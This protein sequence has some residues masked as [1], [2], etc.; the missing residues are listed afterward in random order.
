M[1]EAWFGRLFTV[2]A[3]QGRGAADRRQQKRATRCSDL[4][5]ELTVV[6]TIGPRQALGQI[7]SQFAVCL[8]AKISGDV[9]CLSGQ[10]AVLQCTHKERDFEVDDTK[11]Q[12]DSGD[13][14]ERQ[15]QDQF[16]E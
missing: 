10:A 15:A 1:K 14:R 6:G 8:Y 5:H 4:E 3:I 7:E 11:E 16:L 2:D 13:G 12:Q 9:V